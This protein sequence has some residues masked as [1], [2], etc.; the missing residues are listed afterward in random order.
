M[1]THTGIENYEF[2][3][4]WVSPPGD[5][6]EDLLE[7]RDMTLETLSELLELKVYDVYKLIKG[8]IIIT[9]ELASKLAKAFNMSKT[10]WINREQQYRKQ[11]E[12]GLSHE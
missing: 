9:D 2:N 7:E 6:I 1:H 10:F 12:L 4:D 11:L 8:N 5:T 3:P